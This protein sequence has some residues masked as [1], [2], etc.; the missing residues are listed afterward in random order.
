MEKITKNKEI[1]EP[2]VIPIECYKTKDGK[3]FEHKKEAKEH[4]K[5]LTKYPNLNE[6]DIEWLEH[7]IEKRDEETS[8][9]LFKALKSDKVILAMTHSGGDDPRFETVE[10]NLHA[11]KAVI[12]ALHRRAVGFNYNMYVDGV[13]Y[14]KESLCFDG[15]NIKDVGA[16]PVCFECLSP[17][18]QKTH[19]DRVIKIMNQAVKDQIQVL[20]SHLTIGTY[21]RNKDAENQVE[22]AYRVYYLF[23]NDVQKVFEVA[24]AKKGDGKH[25]SVAELGFDILQQTRTFD[26]EDLK[27]DSH[28]WD[29]KFFTFERVL[30]NICHIITNQ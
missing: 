9:Y 22:E 28:G 3:E 1:M 21:L 17:Q 27:N 12:K 19:R 23:K 10:P 7:F 30:Y 29:D 8:V 2:K 24:G 4:E 18:D 13:I 11:V 6:Y 25:V 16:I 5:L 26:L 20:K 15:R 14:K